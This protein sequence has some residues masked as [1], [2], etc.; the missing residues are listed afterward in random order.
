MPPGDYT[1]QVRAIDRDFNYSET[2]QAQLAVEPDAYIETLSAALNRGNRVVEP[3]K[4]LRQLQ[5]KLTEVAPSDLTVLILGET[6]VG[7]GLAA[8]CQLLSL[9]PR[10]GR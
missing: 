1:F 7:K 5:T 8:R 2:A 10:V 4:V 3:S 9:V 6:G